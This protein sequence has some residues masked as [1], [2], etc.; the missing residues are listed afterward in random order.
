MEM[1]E[2][3]QFK[4]ICVNSE[5]PENL[6]NF[7]QNYGEIVEE[8]VMTPIFALE[9][10][11]IGKYCLN[12]QSITISHADLISENLVLF[13][14]MIMPLKNLIE[15]QFDIK[16]KD[17]SEILFVLKDLEKLKKLGLNIEDCTELPVDLDHLQN[18]VNLET[19]AI[20]GTMVV[21]KIND[22]SSDL[23]MLRNLLISGGKII[24][25]S[26]EMAYELPALEKLELYHVRIETS[27]P[28][29]QKLR[30]LHTRFTSFNSDFREWLEMKLK[31]VEI[32]GT[33]NSLFGQDVLSEIFSSLLPSDWVLPA[34]RNLI[35]YEDFEVITFPL[36]YCPMLTSLNMAQVDEFSK[37]SIDWIEKHSSTLESLELPGL[38]FG[39]NCFELPFFPKLRAFRLNSSYE[40]SPD[41]FFNWIS[42]YSKTMEVLNI[43]GDLE[44]NRLLKVLSDCK[45]IR[46]FR[47]ARTSPAFSENFFRSL[48]KILKENDVTV[49]KPF[50]F[51]CTSMNLSKNQIDILYDL[52]YSE[53]CIV[54]ID[55]NIGTLWE[56]YNEIS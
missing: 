46:S 14:A 52:P 11:L 51:K 56:T 9:F 24:S 42:K 34:L 1:K 28:D 10:P 45:N 5:L 8:I 49:D 19:L 22:I 25:N 30:T 44:R 39:E 7:F 6:A 31:T 4:K 41:R 36:P 43:Y 35:L 23:K 16:H 29:C 13:K 18:M 40:L 20:K 32:L 12:L 26:Q 47:I 50:K 17:A 54:Q 48:F 55:D 3:N 21:L 53:L 15:V 37:E 27:F 33:N 2:L 38:I